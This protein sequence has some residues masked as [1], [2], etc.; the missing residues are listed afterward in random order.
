MLELQSASPAAAFAFEKLNWTQLLLF[1]LAIMSARHHRPGPYHVGPGGEGVRE[2]RLFAPALP[3][4]ID[5]LPHHHS[6]LA[7]V[8]AG[9]AIPLGRQW[10][11]DYVCLELTPGS[12]VPLFSILGAGWS[13]SSLALSQG[14][15]SSVNLSFVTDHVSVK[16]L[17]EHLE[18]T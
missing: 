10:D 17:L 2:R 8:N 6:N 14:H 9:S 3:E 11:I 7:S 5:P 4:P 18:V 16:Q 1:L 13:F 12:P 15:K